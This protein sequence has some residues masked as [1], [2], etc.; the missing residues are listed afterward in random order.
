VEEPA[1]KILDG[2]HMLNYVMMFSFF[3]LAIM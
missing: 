2:F 1:L 3:T